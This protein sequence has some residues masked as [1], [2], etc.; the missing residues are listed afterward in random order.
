MNGIFIS[1]TSFTTLSPAA[2]REVLAAT[3]FAVGVDARPTTEHSAI[4]GHVDVEGPVELTLSFVRRLADGLSEKTLIAL[5][6]I[7]ASPSPEFR[8]KDV[9]DATEGAADYM[10]VRGVWAALTRRTR[11][12]VSDQE[13]RLIWWQGDEIVDEQGRYVDHVGTV[14]ALT[15]QSLRTHFGLGA[16]K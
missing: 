7:A 6:T 16:A 10:D 13:A 3:G 9:I 4:T 8:M 11:K 12:L 2:R 15:H 5:K 1:T 14:S